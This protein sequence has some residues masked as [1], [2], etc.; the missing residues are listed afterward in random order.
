VLFVTHD[1]GL[2]ARFAQK[3]A[4][5]Y[6]GRIVEYGDVHAIYNNPQHPYTMAL[7][8]SVPALTGPRLDR[9]HQIE[10]APPDLKID[11]PGCPFAPRCP[12]ATSRCTT[13][14]PELTPRGPQHTAACWVTATMKGEAVDSDS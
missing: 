14:R 2:V 11:S 8:Q 7:L 10:G 3:V 9:L 6:A 1:L 5:M 12:M 4:V 13:E